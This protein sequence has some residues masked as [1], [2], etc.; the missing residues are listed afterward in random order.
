[1]RNPKKPNLAILA[2]IVVAI[3]IIISGVAVFFFDVLEE[4]SGLD[5]KMGYLSEDGEKIPISSSSGTLAIGSSPLTVYQSSAKN[6]QINGV[7]AE[8]RVKVT[9]QN[10]PD[11][12][13]CDYS[14]SARGDIANTYRSSLDS[15]SGSKS[16]PTGQ[17]VTLT[18]SRID[19]I[20]SWATI[21]GSD[22]DWDLDV[23]VKTGQ[24]SKDASASGTMSFYHTDDD[25]QT[26]SVSTD[27]NGS[28][29]SIILEE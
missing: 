17:W 7:Y 16:I 10:L 19:G 26:L 8:M 25:S 13:T 11:E 15:G 12:V 18:T 6:T 24:K 23:T 1:M 28:Y 21:G 5:M 3:G 9:G 27:V 22:I 14:M 2:V 4:D 20:D 29:L